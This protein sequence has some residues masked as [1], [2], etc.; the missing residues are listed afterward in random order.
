MGRSLAIT[1]TG[2]PAHPSESFHRA[3]EFSERKAVPPAIAKHDG[4]G[5]AFVCSVGQAARS[6]AR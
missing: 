5:C 1:C 4:P 3:R 6:V 2:S